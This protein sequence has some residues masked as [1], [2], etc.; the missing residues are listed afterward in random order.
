M[1]VSR[2]ETRDDVDC[3]ERVCNS[4]ILVSIKFKGEGAEIEHSI[5]RRILLKTRN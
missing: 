3:R 5:V 4:W 2:L 1:R